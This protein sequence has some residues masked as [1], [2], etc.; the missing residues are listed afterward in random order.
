MVQPI[1]QNSILERSFVKKSPRTWGVMFASRVFFFGPQGAQKKT[2]C[3]ILLDRRIA[4]FYFHI[5]VIVLE[6][7][8]IMKG[9]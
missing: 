3:L 1:S 8:H 5:A 2:P 9:F 6:R 7:T 4:T